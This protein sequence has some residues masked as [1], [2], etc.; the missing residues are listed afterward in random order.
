VFSS[1]FRPRLFIGES[2]G[3]IAMWK[4]VAIVV[5]AWIASVLGLIARPL[6]LPALPLRL[7]QRPPRPPVRL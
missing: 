2:G 6:Q 7:I 4:K 3:F 5:V 1:G